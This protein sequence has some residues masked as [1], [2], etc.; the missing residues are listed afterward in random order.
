METAELLPHYP[1]FGV[2]RYHR[3]RCKR[4][5]LVPCVNPEE[6]GDSDDTVIFIPEWVCKLSPRAGGPAQNEICLE[7]NEF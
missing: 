5:S 3:S 7:P 4:V 2:Q 6:H 1:G